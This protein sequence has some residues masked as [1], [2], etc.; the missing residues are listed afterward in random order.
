MK[1]IWIYAVGLIPLGLAYYP[2]K[3]R[4]S[5]PALIAIGFAYLIALRFL[6]IRLGTTEPIGDADD[7]ME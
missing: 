5:G 6:A 3:E 2:I 1:P 7:E 4:V